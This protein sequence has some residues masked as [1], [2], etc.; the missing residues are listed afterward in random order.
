M[1]ILP[2]PD[3]EAHRTMSGAQL[4]ALELPR[5][6]RDLGASDDLLRWVVAWSDLGA[7]GYLH[8]ST[9]PLNMAQQLLRP[10]PTVPAPKRG[11]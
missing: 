10:Q 5:L 2:L 11:R 9:L 6:L 8:A 4:T 3:T 1:A 7:R